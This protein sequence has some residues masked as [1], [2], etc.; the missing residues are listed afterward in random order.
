[1]I[2]NV[3]PMPSRARRNAGSR[4]IESPWNSTST[5]L[6]ETVP[7]ITLISVVL[8]APFGP[9]SPR[10]SLAPSV[11]LTS[12]TAVRPA[13]TW[14]APRTSNNAFITGRSARFR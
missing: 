9:I 1:M 8:P 4:L 2:W 12:L 5:L 7:L 11:K 10:I 13:N 3:R 6:S 14:V